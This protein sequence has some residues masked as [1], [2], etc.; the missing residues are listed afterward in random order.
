MHFI[1]YEPIWALCYYALLMM[2]D[3]WK[4]WV[5]FIQIKF[6]S[7]SMMKNDMQIGA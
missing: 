2:I 7:N 1:L 3:W 4:K 6:D 5:D